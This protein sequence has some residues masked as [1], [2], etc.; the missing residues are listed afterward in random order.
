MTGR[1]IHTIHAE[2]EYR[3]Q[4]AEIEFA[5]EAGRLCIRNTGVA[6]TASGGLSIT[7]PG[8]PHSGKNPT[9]TDQ[10]FWQK[11]SSLHFAFE[12]KAHAKIKQF[13]REYGFLKVLPS[14]KLEDWEYTKAAVEWFNLLTS[15]TRWLKDRNLGP[16]REA[17]DNPGS[18]SVEILPGT[19]TMYPVILKGIDQHFSID[20]LDYTSEGAHLE[21]DDR[22]LA[23]AWHSI[24]DAV[25]SQLNEST[26]TL[27][28]APEGFAHTWHFRAKGAF[29]AAFLQWYFQELAGYEIA[30]CRRRGCENPVIPP[31]RQRGSKQDYCS[32]RCRWAESKRKQ[33][34]KT[35]S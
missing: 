31:V 24:L 18:G 17:I 26:F 7:W 19:K 5:K 4:P 11:V 33:R 32:K 15:M 20:L 12:E 16:L 10:N 8:S 34:E 9:R 27:A 14:A 28:S 22:L 35:S 6:Q 23:M 25:N 3:C 30:K 21:P 2:I 29:E 13:Y 1:A